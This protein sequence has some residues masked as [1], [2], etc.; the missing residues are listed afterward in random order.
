MKHN[1]GNAHMW[2][3]PCIGLVLLFIWLVDLGHQLALDSNYKQMQAFSIQANNQREK[4]AAA[5]EKA[6]AAADAA[7]SQAAADIAKQ[8]RLEAIAVAKIDAS[9]VKQSNWLDFLTENRMLFGLFAVGGMLCWVFG[10]RQ[11]HKTAMVTQTTQTF[12]INQGQPVTPVPQYVV[13]AMTI[14]T[15]HQNPTDRF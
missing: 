11:K 3:L 13:P 15:A 10:I 5:V 6:Q 14:T 2:V 1:Q 12:I 4:R 8:K 9:V 7:A